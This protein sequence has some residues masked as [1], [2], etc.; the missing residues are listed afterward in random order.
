MRCRGRAGER[1]GGREGGEREG[2]NEGRKKSVKVGLM[3]EMRGE[4][5]SRIGEGREETRGRKEGGW[6]GWM[7]GGGRTE[8]DREVGR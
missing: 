8:A 5:R 4:E 7:E 3:E 6:D 1:E 2:G